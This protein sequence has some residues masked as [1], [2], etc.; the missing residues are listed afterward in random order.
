MTSGK[1]FACNNPTNGIFNC[2]DVILE[3][4]EKKKQQIEAIDKKEKKKGGNLYGNSKD[5]GVY[6][7]EC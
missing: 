3:K 4:I 7:P 1:C 2:A 5:D 6:C